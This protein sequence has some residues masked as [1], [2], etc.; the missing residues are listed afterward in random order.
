VQAIPPILTVFSVAWSVCLSV[1][2]LSLL[3]TLLKPFNRFRYHLAG[4]LVGP[5]TLCVIWV[6]PRPPA[7]G[8]IW[9]SNH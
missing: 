7:D 8:E 9:G 3:Y 5:M 4:T 2:R 6:R 1:S